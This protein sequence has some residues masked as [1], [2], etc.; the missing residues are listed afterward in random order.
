MSTPPVAVSSPAFADETA[1]RE[2]HNADKP[3]FANLF[4]FFMPFS[5]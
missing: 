4:M 3:T 1:A 5:I 2:P